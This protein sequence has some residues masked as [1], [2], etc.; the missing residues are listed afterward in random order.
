MP[1]VRALSFFGTPPAAERERERGRAGS[2]TGE[3]RAQSVDGTG[4]AWGVAL[5]GPLGRLAGSLHLRTL[6]PSPVAVVVAFV[7]AI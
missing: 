7:P 3:E 2:E 5:V 6:R 1:H 4:M